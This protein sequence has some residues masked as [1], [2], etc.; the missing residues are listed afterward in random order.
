MTLLEKIIFLSKERGLNRKALS[1]QSGIPY[2]T[3][4]NWFQ[5]GC[6]SMNLSTFA[7]LCRFFGVTM[8]SM[9]Y[10]DKDIVYLPAAEFESG[11]NL[12]IEASIIARTY[13][14]APEG[15]KDSVAKLLD[16]KRDIN[17]RLLKEA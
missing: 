1:D 17:S 2:T 4:S 12:S 8:E 5:R 7:R 16:V 9:A 10:D 14:N 3:V 13:E 15:M 11:N 6:D